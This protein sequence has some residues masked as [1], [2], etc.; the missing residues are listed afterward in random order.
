[1]LKVL[2]YDLTRRYKT[3]IGTVLILLVIGLLVHFKLISPIYVSS[4]GTETKS[5]VVSYLIILPLLFVAVNNFRKELFEKDGYLVFSIPVSPVKLFSAKLVLAFA[6]FYLYSILT[7]FVLVNSDEK[8]MSADPIP[9]ILFAVTNHLSIIITGLFAMI[10]A[11]ILFRKSKIC[12]GM[13]II[14]FL[15]VLLLSQFVIGIIDGLGLGLYVSARHD[16]VIFFSGADLIRQ[17]YGVFAAGFAGLALL[18]SVGIYLL[19][20]RLYGKK[21]EI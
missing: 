10:L 19:S 3:I 7:G 9:S 14:I 4:L 11:K 5:S 6:E 20:V 18:Y 16:T 13:S 17:Y 21:I 2:G 8:V 12:Q 1:M 15:L